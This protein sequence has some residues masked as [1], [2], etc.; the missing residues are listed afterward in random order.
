M[1]IQGAVAAVTGAG[2]GLGKQ[3]ALDLAARGARVVGCDLSDEALEG[4]RGEAAERGLD[5]VGRV[6]D[7]GDEAAVRA[8]FAVVAEQSGRLDVLVNNAGIVRDALLVKVKDGRV[9]S[10]SLADFEAVVRVN[11]TGVFL[12]AREAASIMAVRGGGVIINVSSLSR[13][14]NFG[15]TNYSATKA[16]VAAMTVTW[17]K[18]LARYGIR[19]A[20]IAPGWIAT[21]MV[22]TMPPD[23]LQRVVDG[24]PLKRLGQPEEVSRTVQFIIENDYVTGRVLDIDGGLRI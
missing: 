7:V 3:I 22:M 2:R 20:A 8:F 15:Q 23:I 5:V 19:V 24:V 6:C 16:G 21:D 13:V 4:L 1:N 17:S 14:G 11:L 10:M 18:E 9:S 12:C